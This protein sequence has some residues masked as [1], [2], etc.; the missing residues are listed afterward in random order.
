MYEGNKCGFVGEHLSPTRLFYPRNLRSS[1][2]IKQNIIRHSTTQVIQ[3]TR[4][5]VTHVFGEISKIRTF[6]ENGEAIFAFNYFYW[7]NRISRQL[8]WSTFSL[9]AD[10]NREKS[11]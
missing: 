9:C 3:N 2:L 10:L 11:V 5:Y 6:N 4:S 7:L 8:K 1:I